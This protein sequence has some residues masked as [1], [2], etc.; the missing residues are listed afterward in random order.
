MQEIADHPTTTS[1]AA[2]QLAEAAARAE[3]W[4]GEPFVQTD[5]DAAVAL[6]PDTARRRA[7][8]A[9]LAEMES[10]R[11]A[12]S[13]DWRVRY[14]LMLGLERILTDKPPS[15]RSGTELRRHQIDALAGMLTELIAANEH[16][17]ELNGNG[18]VADELAEAPDEDDEDEP[19]V[20]DEE[21]EQAAELVADGAEQL[22][23][24]R[25]LV[26]QRLR[27]LPLLALEV[28]LDG[29]EEGGVRGRERGALRDGAAVVA[30]AVSAAAG[31]ERCADREQR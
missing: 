16:P 9:A 18:A 10:G 4:A 24:V 27:L 8:D 1:D 2:A 15:L 12:P 23:T 14:A 6:A 22:V 13:N 21:A 5:E 17:A 28:R 26:E 20:D 7:L 31:N 19:L 3:A 25:E 29:D 30:V 11:A